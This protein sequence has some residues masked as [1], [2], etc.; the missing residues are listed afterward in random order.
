M[1]RKLMFGAVAFVSA[2]VVAAAG[3]AEPSTK[4][5]P[6][7]SHDELQNR[8]SD[9]ALR[10]L[11]A[12][13]KADYE[14]GHLPGAVWVELKALQNLAKSDK[15]SDPASWSK[16]L[17][18]L[19]IGPDSEVFVYDG[20]QQHNAGPVWWLLGYGGVAKIGLV[21]GGYQNWEKDK[22]PVTTDVPKV[23]AR[24][25]DVHIDTP[26]IATRADV[27][28]AAKTG[29]EQI[30]DVRTPA[31]YT[32]EQKRRT[33]KSGHIPT[34][35]LLDTNLLVATD[36]RL[37]DPAK[38]REVLTKIGIDPEKSAIVYS[39]VGARSSLTVFLLKRLGLEKVRHYHVGFS[40][41]SSDT[42][43]PVV[44][45]DQPGTY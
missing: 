25:F 2:A 11:D 18:S 3:A 4:I 9:P 17:A 34:A 16:V 40:D 30:V 1:K 23:E 44:S 22:R 8:L 37:F 32:G 38:Q 35:R 7:I 31:E 19:G 45:G 15:Q 26:R 43:R 21:D 33:G 20:N 14:K 10:L 36:G 13:P 29:A 5:P 42:A 41:W 28:Q 39:V 24:E 27:E 6:L 12:R